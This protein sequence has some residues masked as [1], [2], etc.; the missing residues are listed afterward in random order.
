[1]HSYIVHVRFKY[2]TIMKRAYG[3]IKARCEY[4][5]CERGVIV[6]VID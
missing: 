1:M 2:M 3:Y 6:V 5:I 4:S